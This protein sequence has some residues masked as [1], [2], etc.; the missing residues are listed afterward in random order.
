MLKARTHYEQVPLRIIQ[1]ITG[2]QIVA[3][4]ILLEQDSAT[5]SIKRKKSPLLIKSRSKTGSH[6]RL[7]MQGKKP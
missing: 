3:P 6:H 4:V 2:E 1:E 7:Q 5:S